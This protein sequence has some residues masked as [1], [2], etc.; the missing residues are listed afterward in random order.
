MSGSTRFVGFVA[1]V[2]FL[3]GC[4]TYRPVVWQAG[5][6]VPGA[7]AVRGQD[8]E[9]KVGDEVRVTLHDGEQAQGDLVSLD[10]E[11]IVIGI[12]DWSLGKGRTRTFHPGE[13]AALEKVGTDVA[14]TTAAVA[15]GVLVVG[16]LVWAAVAASME[17]LT[18]GSSGS[19]RHGQPR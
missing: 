10:G 1:L 16:L 9:L 11:T 13:I 17:P 6:Q 5:D 2:F 18:L 7:E 8:A 15:G 12:G 3:T 14:A 4:S 19:A